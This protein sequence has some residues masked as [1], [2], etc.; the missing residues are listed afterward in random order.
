MSWG[1]HNLSRQHEFRS[2]WLALDYSRVHVS[3]PDPI[4]CRAMTASTKLPSCLMWLRGG[5]RRALAP[6]SPG[7]REPVLTN[8]PLRQPCTTSFASTRLLAAV[9]DCVW[10]SQGPTIVFCSSFTL[11]TL[12]LCSPLLFWSSIAY[13]STIQTLGSPSRRCSDFVSRSSVN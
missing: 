6:L 9:S 12:S 8:S 3:N 10:R 11:L 1:G 4:V 13:T 7:N 5:L 2:V